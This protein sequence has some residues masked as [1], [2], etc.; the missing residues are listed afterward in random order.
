[1]RASATIV[2]LGVHEVE[3]RDLEI[4]LTLAEE[5]HFGRTAERLHVSTA[6]VSQTIKKME[7]RIGVPL[8]ERTSRQVTLTPV[9]QRFFDDVG[10]A[11]Q[12][13]EE[14]IARAVAAGRGVD[15]VLRVGFIGTAVGQFVIE[16][17]D[18]FHGRHPDCEV[19]IVE[20]RYSEGITYLHSDQVD[21]ML[22]GAPSLKP[23]VTESAILFRE[24]PV[25]AVSSRHPFA[26]RESVSMDD[27]ARDKVLRPRSFADEEDALVVPPTTP[28]GRTIERGTTF[29]TIQE[30]LA[31]IGAGK[32]VFVVPTH[33]RRYDARPDVAYV[34]IHDG[35]PFG[36]RLLW[37]TSGE[38]ARI[39]AFVRAATDYVHHHPDPLLAS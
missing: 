12:Q 5:L 39:R 34:P 30:M 4:F 1:M 15:G 21:V 25:L 36:W 38:N 27:L 26:R 29:G 33:A 28:G 3:R 19:Q 17:A 37:L 16:V 24:P 23:D 31:L 35:Q 6:R 7:R 8:F 22:V 18:L 14:G 20:C 2:N 10:P 13:I 32:G 11:F 9:G